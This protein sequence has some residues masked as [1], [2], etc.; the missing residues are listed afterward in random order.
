MTIA[1]LISQTVNL[2]RL[3]RKNGVYFEEMIYP[4]GFMTFA[5]Q[6]RCALSLGA[7]FSTSI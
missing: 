4:D 1:T 7:E 5:A 2:V 6:D 3:L